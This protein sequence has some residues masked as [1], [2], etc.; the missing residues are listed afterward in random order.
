MV[1]ISSAPAKAK[2]SPGPARLLLQEHQFCLTVGVPPRLIS[3]WQIRQLRS[4]LYLS[5][6]T[7]G[8][9]LTY[10]LTSCSSFEHRASNAVLHSIPVFS[11]V[12]TGTIPRSFQLLPLSPVLLQVPQDLPFFLVPWGFHS[13][14]IR[15]FTSYFR[16]YL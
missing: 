15:L 1:Q 10:F 14:L 12:C 13:F 4:V 16:L 7:L 11:Q 6:P 8:E 5:K 3:F 9:D 2:L